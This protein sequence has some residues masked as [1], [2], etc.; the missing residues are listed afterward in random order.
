MG[1]PTELLPPVWVDWLRSTEGLVLQDRLNI[2]AL[3][4]AELLPTNTSVA[5]DVPGVAMD[6]PKEK[7]EIVFQKDL[8]LWNH[9]KP[10]RMFNAFT[11]GNGSMPGSD[12]YQR[13]DIFEI[14]DDQ[15]EAIP[16]SLLD[17]ETEG[18]DNL[19]TNLHG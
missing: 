17:H 5:S 15:M 12:I 19:P 3:A 9:D 16:S 1:Y 11:V 14:S 2:N 10:G 7:R 4:I 8:S 6:C 13:E 18:D